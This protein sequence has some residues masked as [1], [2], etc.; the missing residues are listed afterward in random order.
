MK[1]V[2]IVYATREGQT[3]RIAEHIGAEV[4]TRGLA[5]DVFEVR[6][7]P[8][9]FD[10]NAYAA[11]V[12]AASVHTGKHE[13][14]MVAFAKQHRAT[15]EQM[16]SALLSV[17][18]SEADVESP[19][20]SPEKRDKADHDVHHVIE[21]FFDETGWRPTRVKPVA[22]ALLYTKY[23]VIIRFI[24][25]QM[26]KRGTGSTDTSRDHEYTDWAALD[27]FVEELLATVA[28]RPD[29][30]AASIQHERP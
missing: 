28:P 16:P 8:P 15:L 27:H 21:Q 10:L 9:Q 25:K 7:L 13:R 12:V 11:V 18:L 19:S 4:R 5:A 29:E 23:N 17:S 6:A 22:G 26:A 20:A 3:R 2:L 24:M 30:R 1:P 14:E